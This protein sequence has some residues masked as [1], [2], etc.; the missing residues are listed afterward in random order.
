[1]LNFKCH[2][3]WSKAFFDVIPQ[4]KGLSIKGNENQHLQKQEENK[5]NQFEEENNKEATKQEEIQSTFISQHNTRIHTSNERE[6][7]VQ[8]NSL[9][10]N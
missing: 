9:L 2:Q 8:I 4:R 1:M 3:S 5:S 7:E 6:Q 10:E